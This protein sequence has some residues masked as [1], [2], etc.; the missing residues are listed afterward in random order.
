M[1]EIIMNQTGPAI[2]WIGSGSGL[3]QTGLVM[4]LILANVEQ[5]GLPGVV[6]A[7]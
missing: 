6:E 3:G 2:K 4:Y 5:P 7:E 1:I